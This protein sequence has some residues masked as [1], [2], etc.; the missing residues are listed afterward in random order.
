MSTIICEA[1]Q[2][3]ET[4]ESMRKCRQPSAC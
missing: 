3:L 1:A 4:V 2:D